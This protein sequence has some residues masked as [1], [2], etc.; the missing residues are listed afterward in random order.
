MWVVI[1]AFV[2]FKLGWVRFQRKLILNK[3]YFKYVLLRII[4][5]EL[6]I[7]EPKKLQK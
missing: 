4:C 2:W 1:K 7:S 3:K 5:S 6:D